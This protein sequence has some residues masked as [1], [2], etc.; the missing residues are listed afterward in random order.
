MNISCQYTKFYCIFKRNYAINASSI[1]WRALV[2]ESVVSIKQCIISL[3]DAL[4]CII[5]MVILS[6]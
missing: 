2:G 4:I 5:T 6:E 3:T 1:D